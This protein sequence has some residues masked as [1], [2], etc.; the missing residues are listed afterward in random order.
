MT[1][2]QNNPAVPADVKAQAK[3]ELA[4]GVPFVSDAQLKS[5]LHKAGVSNQAANAIVDENS[6][7]RINGL[8]SSLSVLAVIA[9]IAVF[10]SLRIPTEQP[11]SAREDMTIPR[12]T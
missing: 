7:A 2:I 1:G 12:A 11:A 4:G 10:F 3:V 9:L 5:A 6:T 8:R